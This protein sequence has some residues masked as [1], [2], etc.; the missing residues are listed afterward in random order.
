VIS[1]DPNLDIAAITNTFNMSRFVV[2][3][4]LVEVETFFE[5]ITLENI[6]PPTISSKSS[7]TNEISLTIKSTEP[8]DE[9]EVYGYIAGAKD[10]TLMGTTTANKFTL[11]DLKPNQKYYLKVRG[12]K[13]L[14]NTFSQFS[15]EEIV[16]TVASN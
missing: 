14:T 8:F 4:S 12:K 1:D 2:L 13:A 6:E 3:K 9:Y 10:P 5:K 11:G 15:K 16:H 7:S